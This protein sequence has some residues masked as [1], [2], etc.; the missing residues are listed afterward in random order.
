MTRSMLRIQRRLST[1]AVLLT[2][3][4]LPATTAFAQTFTRITAGPLVNDAAASRA[5]CWVDFDHD[6]ALDLFVSNGPPAGQNNM[7]FKNSGYPAHGFT[8]VTG[9]PIVTD[10]GRFDGA[11]WGDV[12]NDGDFDCFIVNWYGD[13]DHF[14]LNDGDGTFT[15]V[16]TGAPVTTPGY[17]EACSWGDY[18]NDGLID[19]YVTNS[20]IGTGDPNFLYHNDGG[21]NFTRIVSRPRSRGRLHLPRRELGGLRRRRRPRSLHRERGQPAE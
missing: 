2:F 9:D 7:L 11:S 21:G 8:A 20:G 19:L 17:S 6:G 18:D 16:T 15:Q 1:A 14:F 3:F 10:P 4:L 5:V 13:N 12:E